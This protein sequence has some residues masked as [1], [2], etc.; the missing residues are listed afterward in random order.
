MKSTNTRPVALAAAALGA[1]FAFAAH[2]DSPPVRIVML[3]MAVTLDYVGTERS[4]AAATKV[5][6]IDRLRIVY[7]AA[8]VDP[9]THRVRLLNLQHFIAGHYSPAA[10]DP[11]IMPLDDA[12]LD[13]GV[14][15]YRLHFRAAVVHGDPI[16]IDIDEVSRRLT[17]H[18]QQHPQEAIISGPYAIDSTPITGPEARVAGSATR[19]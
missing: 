13:L 18:P 15:P 1:A 17:I 3:N 4:K 10:P 16:I 2:A 19:R 5:G 6:D 8:A 14:T 11:R 9:T 7:D 12:W